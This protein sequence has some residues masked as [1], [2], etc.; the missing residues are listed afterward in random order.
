MATREAR[1]GALDADV[2][3][4]AVDVS[5]ADAVAKLAIH[6][7]VREAPA[8]LVFQRGP[9]IATRIDGFADRETVAQ[10]AEHALL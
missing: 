5:N 2:G 8:L 1:A 10:A 9:K 7:D 6:F 3:F 4:L